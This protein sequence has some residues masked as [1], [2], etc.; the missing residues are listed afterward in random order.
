MR[1]S[2]SAKNPTLAAWLNNRW[3]IKNLLLLIEEQFNV[4]QD[5]E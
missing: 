5:N 1:L 4:Q 3:K 2:S